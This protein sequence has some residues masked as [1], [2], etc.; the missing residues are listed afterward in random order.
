MIYNYLRHLLLLSFVLVFG[1]ADTSPDIFVEVHGQVLAT[2]AVIKAYRNSD[3]FKTQKEVQRQSLVKFVNEK[4]VGDLL[5]RVAGYEQHLEKNPEVQTILQ[6][7]KRHLLIGKNGV[8]FQSI[9]PANIEI[10][11]EELT[12]FYIKNRLELRVDHIRVQ[13]LALADSLYQL[14]K[15]GENFEKLA[16]N[17]AHNYRVKEFFGIGERDPIYEMTAFELAAGEISK[18]VK[19]ADGYFI[20]KLLET[21][22]RQLPPFESVRDSLSEQFAGIK[23]ALFMSSYFEDI[24]RQFNEKYN[25][26]VLQEICRAFENRNGD[27]RLNSQR[28]RKF[29][30]EPAITSDAGQKTVADLARFYESMSQEASFP[31][32][33][34]A[35][36]HA[37][38][39]MAI[40]PDLMYRDVILRGLDKHE[41]FDAAISSLQ[42]SL[43]EAQYYQQFIADKVNVTDADI[44][45]YYGEHFDK[46]KQMQKP[47]A[48]ARIRQILEDEQTKKAVDD[49]TKQL[50]KLFIIRFNSMAIQR[51]LNELN[52]EKRGLAQ[53][54]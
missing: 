31:I 45:G 30:D 22:E 13:S 50:R 36:A 46:F 1:C 32:L 10:S 47:A 23:K 9:L 38:A 42:D 25:D 33:Q 26:T 24:H 3:E 21:R 17:Y 54:F 15:N 20:I 41:H 39:R 19:N 18:P 52:S 49:V 12:A 16:Q 5:L 44:A 27:Y 6:D 48:F 37:L 34:L 11:E 53:K 14:L 51:S 29:L 8:L 40:E 35:D 2:D 28:L 43:V 7:R 4:F